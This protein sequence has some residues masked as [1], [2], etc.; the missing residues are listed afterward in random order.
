MILIRKIYN[1]VICSFLIA[2]SVHEKKKYFR[3]IIVLFIEL[4]VLIV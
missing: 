4:H 3:D 1:Y 2:G